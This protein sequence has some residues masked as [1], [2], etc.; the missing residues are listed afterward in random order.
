MIRKNKP[1]EIDDT[2]IFLNDTLSREDSIKDLSKIIISNNEPFVFS[3]NA[4]WGSGKTTFV[5]MWQKF[6]KKEHNVNSI[7]F[8][9][10]EDDFSQE[11]LIS[12][13][14]E[15][16]EYINI[17]FPPKSP[18]QNK[19][20]KLIN[21]GGNIVRKVAP[22]VV[23]GATGGILD[24][25]AGY[26]AA[27]S[28]MGEGLTKS[29]I[30][31]YSDDKNILKE[32]KKSIEELLMEIDGEKPFIIFI[33]EL[34]RCRPL[35]S[36][37]LLERIKHVFGIKKL[38]FVLSLDKSQLTESI[39]SQYGN[40]DA[41]KYLKRFIDLE[42]NL[43]NVS[44]GLFCDN[45]Y[46]K[47]DL[48]SILMGKGIAKEINI[49]F[50]HL[51]IMKQLAHLFQLTLRDIEQVFTKLNLLFSTI[52]PRLFDSHFRVFVFFEMLKSYDSNLYF[53]LIKGNDIEKVKKLVLSTFVNKNT[54]K[55]VSIIFEAIIDSIGKS[56]EEYTLLIDDKKSELESGKSQ[57]FEGM[58]RLEQTI[59]ILTTGFDEWNEYKL[60]NLVDKV[61][62]K[63]EF[64]EKFN[65]ETV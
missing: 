45:L 57:E 29:L 20:K 41:N 33:D 34:D 37:E 65:F 32:F 26:E 16:N 12:I 23:K 8:S 19:F 28:A 51:T 35:Y 61:I 10:W 46:K 4:S 47:F 56:D 62:S 63:I 17:T 11:P 59:R 7:Y 13:L 48:E 31:K 22:A 42:Y 40:I 25:D 60:N 2:D 64:T 44:V 43:N 1:L 14:G 3:I 53:N 38:T 55:D 5:K 30:E 24:L 39:K 6:L 54:Y 49:T 50:H 27:L 21:S 52:Q 58:E 9:A 18:Q 15:L 36:I